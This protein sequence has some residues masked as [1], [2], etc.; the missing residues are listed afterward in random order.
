MSDLAWLK[1][2]E[3]KDFNVTG[4]ENSILLMNV[5]SRPGLVDAINLN[6]AS[7]HLSFAGSYLHLVILIFWFHKH[8][9]FLCLICHCF[10]LSSQKQMLFPR[11]WN[12]TCSLQAD[13]NRCLSWKIVVRILDYHFFGLKGRRT[14]LILTYDLL[15]AA[16]AAATNKKIAPETFSY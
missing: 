8:V 14:H 13:K 3:G 12:R 2:V 1:C 16:Y 5:F 6:C 10:P 11:T 15:W 4:W 7:K 9:T